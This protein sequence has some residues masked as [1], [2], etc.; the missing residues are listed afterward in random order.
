LFP[1]PCYE[2]PSFFLRQ[3]LSARHKRH[4]SELE[5]IKNLIKEENEFPGSSYFFP[6]FI[7]VGRAEIF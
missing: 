3:K 6:F 7:F 4:A 1:S 5:Y 2:K